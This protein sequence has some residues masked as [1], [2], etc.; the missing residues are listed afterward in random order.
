MENPQ[1]EPASAGKAIPYMTVDGAAKAMDWYEKAFGAQ[2]GMTMPAPDGRLMHAE[3]I[4]FGAEVYLS[5]EFPE[6]GGPACRNP[7]ALGATTVGMHLMVDDVD[8]AVERAAAEGATIAF[9]PTDMFWGHRFAKIVDPF[10][11]H[12]SFAKVVRILTED[13]MAAAAAEAMGGGGCG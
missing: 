13:E 7:L 5:D 1:A 9:P 3:V 12:W 11:H 6:M 10:G 4:A 2:K 8:G